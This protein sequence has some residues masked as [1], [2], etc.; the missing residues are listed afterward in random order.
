[1]RVHYKSIMLKSFFSTARRTF[2]AKK[3]LSIRNLSTIFALST[4][5]VKSAVAVFRV[6]GPKAMTVL[7]TMGG[8]KTRPEHGRVYV[9]TLRHPK[10]HREIDKAVLLWFSAPN[11]FTGED[12]VELQCHGSLA[13]IRALT[14][15][16]ASLEGLRA[17]EPG[18]FA[19][20]AFLNKKMDLTDVE[21]LADLI[22]AETDAQLDQAIRGRGQLVSACARWMQQLKAARANFEVYIDFSED[23]DISPSTVMSQASCVLKKTA[24]EMSEALRT[25]PQG[26]AIRT[27]FKV[28]ITGRPNVGKST[29]VNLISRQEASIVSPFAGTTRDLIRVSVD[30]GGLPIILC[31]TAGARW[32]SR[33]PVEIE[34]IRR[35]RDFSRQAHLN[36]LVTDDPMLV[37]EDHRLLLNEGSTTRE[38]DKC[39]SIVVLN[40][41]D[42]FTNFDLLKRTVPD[43]NLVD[44]AVSCHSGQGVGNLI[45]GIVTRLADRFAVHDTPALVVRERQRNLIQFLQLCVAYFR[46]H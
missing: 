20:R 19:R 4:G 26:E 31:D 27:G 6:S 18:E 34:G 46:R 38:S 15:A 5:Y 17:A 14:S 21:S 7:L 44:Y 45:E 8:F 1:M 28:A 22:E 30:L 16:L 24:H 37:Q 9:R 42:L 23:Q 40:K 36:I 3:Y 2:P 32:N 41:V 12:V 33:D 11:S 39:N 35:A 25:A 43:L 29:L 13:V 10:S